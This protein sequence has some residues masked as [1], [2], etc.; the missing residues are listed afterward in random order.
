MVMVLY[1]KRS[2]K[3]VSFLFMGMKTL[4]KSLDFMLSPP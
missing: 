2:S 3:E 1:T 4:S